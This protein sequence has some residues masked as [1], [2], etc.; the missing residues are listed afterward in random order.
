MK[1][2]KNSWL[3]IGAFVIVGILIV[4]TIIGVIVGGKSSKKTET[5][6]TPIPTISDTA[7]GS[8]DTATTDDAQA[9]A[10]ADTNKDDS[11]S[12]NENYDKKSNNDS[13]KSTDDNSAKATKKPS[14]TAK[15]KNKNNDSDKSLA[16]RGATGKDNEISF[17][18]LQ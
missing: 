5:V 4:G 6:I 14:K 3:T 1:K 11:S 7:S 10:T 2:K 15:P 12:K 17:S 18:D 13:A 9:Q 8:S 16:E